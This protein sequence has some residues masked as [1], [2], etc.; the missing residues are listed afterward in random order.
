[1]IQLIHFLTEHAEGLI[2]FTEEPYPL[3]FSLFAEKPSVPDGR[4]EL[5]TK[6]KR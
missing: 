2:G 5:T 1:M 3:S 4:R 6:Q